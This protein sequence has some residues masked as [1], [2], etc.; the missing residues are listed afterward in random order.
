MCHLF[1]EAPEEDGF[2]A[3]GVVDEALREKHHALREVVLREP[4]HHPLLL[5]VGPAGDV[6]YQVAKVLPVPAN[7]KPLTCRLMDGKQTLYSTRLQ[8]SFSI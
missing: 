4:W 8:L 5:H 2:L 1:D 3:Q 7:T 6:D